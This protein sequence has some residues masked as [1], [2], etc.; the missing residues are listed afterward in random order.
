[1]EGGVGKG[2]EEEKGGV[3][4]CGGSGCGGVGEGERERMGGVLLEV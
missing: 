2:V 4:S 1:M 3:C